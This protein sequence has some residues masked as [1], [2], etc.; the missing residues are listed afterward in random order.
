[1]TNKKLHNKETDTHPK[2]VLYSSA[3]CLFSLLSAIAISLVLTLYPQAVIENGE[4]PNHWALMMCMLG[5]TG[6]FVHGVGFVPINKFARSL[7]A[8]LVAWSLM[9]GSIIL[10]SLQ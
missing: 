1:M 2:T 10:M 7:F 4:A 8:P 3:A 9:Y 5:V 6:G